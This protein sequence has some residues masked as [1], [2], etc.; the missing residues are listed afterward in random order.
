MRLFP[1][2][3]VPLFLTLPVSAQNLGQLLPSV[4]N[5]VLSQ[6]TRQ[7]YNPY[8]YTTPY[9][10]QSPYGYTG[11]N[12]AQPQTLLPVIIQTLAQQGRPSSYGNPYTGGYQ[13]PY[14]SYPQQNYGS[15]PYGGG[16]PQQNYG[17]NYSGTVNQ[18]YQ[19]VLGRN[20]DPQ[21][22]A[23]FTGNLS[24]GRMNLSQVRSALAYSDEARYTING[25]Y[26]RYLCRN[27]D[28]QGLSTFS[29]QLA[30]GGSIQQVASA[31]ASSPEAQNR[32]PCY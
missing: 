7:P 31:I 22:L 19:Q 14:S 2:L 13:N 25:L 21:G 32:G 9:P 15:S 5:G 23:T 16:Y 1:S 26:Q 28:P 8:G 4:I 29:S 12:Y 24:S 27:A 17:Q 20:A 3:L 6:Q 11:Q 18:L 30:N 10:G